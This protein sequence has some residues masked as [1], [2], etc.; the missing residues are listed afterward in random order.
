MNYQVDLLSRCVRY[1][2]YF[3]L[4]TPPN[5]LKGYEAWARWSAR[6]KIC[7]CEAV[8]EALSKGR[9]KFRNIYVHGSSN[10]GK[11]F[12]LSPLKVIFNTFSNPATGSFAWIV[13][14]QAEVIFLNDFRWDP[15]LIAWA[16]L[17]QA[18][19]GDVVHLPA[20]KTFS[21]RD[22][23]LTADTPFFATADAPM[24]LIRGGSVDRTNAEMMDVR[25]RFFH[26][27]KKIPQEQRVF[28]PCGRCFARFNLTNVNNDN[29]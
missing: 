23:E 17:L 19:Q 18:L 1:T 5:T 10:C 20:P 4:T 6:P 9:G 16:D 28:S 8:Y 13:A 3:S 2:A 29:Q 15:K 14:E 12:I 24:V 7:F 22:L 27:W 21:Q 26:F 25:W 11:S